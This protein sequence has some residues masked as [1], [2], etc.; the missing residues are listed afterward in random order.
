M[1][2][3]NPKVISEYISVPGG[4]VNYTRTVTP[5]VTETSVNV[6]YL[7]T[8]NFENITLTN[9]TSDIKYVTL[10]Y[11]SYVYDISKMSFN[12]T[13]N[14]NNCNNVLT[15]NTDNE[16]I[17]ISLPENFVFPTTNQTQNITLNDS[18]P[19]NYFVF[20]KSFSIDPEAPCEF[21]TETVKEN[22]QSTNG[23]LQIKS[24]VITTG[25]VTN[26]RHEIKLIQGQFFNENGNFVITERILGTYNIE[27]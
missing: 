19:M 7:Y 11:G 22:W 4:I 20:M 1:A 3:A 23:I 10:P 13:T 25:N 15:G 18:A 14:F 16:I 8:I 6:S 17:Q 2:P 24:Q 27:A 12:F 26:Y 21:P 5:M 9:G